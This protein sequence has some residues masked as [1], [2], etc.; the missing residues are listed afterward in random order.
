MYA[1]FAVAGV[2]AGF[3]TFFNSFFASLDSPDAPGHLI[4]AIA[5]PATWIVGLVLALVL[6]RKRRQSLTVGFSLLLV[7]GVLL[8]ADTVL[9]VPLFT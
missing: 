7:L 8:L 2:V 3:F 1:G 6:A 4:F 9:L 5:L